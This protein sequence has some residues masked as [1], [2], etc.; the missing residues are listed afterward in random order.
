MS[1]RLLFRYWGQLCCQYKERYRYFVS[2]CHQTP[3]KAS[4]A[5][6]K[7]GCQESD[8][9]DEATCSSQ[10]TP[11][12]RLTRLSSYMRGYDRP[13]AREVMHLTRPIESTRP[14]QTD[15]TLINTCKMWLHLRHHSVT[16]DVSKDDTERHEPTHWSHLSICSVVRRS[17][18]TRMEM[19]VI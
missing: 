13:K 10:T 15:V 7:T 6:V 14:W 18:Y 4:L 17:S 1:S 19:S 9:R 11:V 16:I 8:A 12:K 5:N 2:C 3:F